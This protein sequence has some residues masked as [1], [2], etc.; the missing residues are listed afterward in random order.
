MYVIFLMLFKVVFLFQFLLIYCCYIEIQ[1]IFRYYFIPV[2]LEKLTQLIRCQ[3][4][5]L[6]LIR[7]ICLC[8][9]KYF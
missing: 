3:I 4:L 6:Y 1:F 2:Q 8:C 5:N 9:Y 7:C